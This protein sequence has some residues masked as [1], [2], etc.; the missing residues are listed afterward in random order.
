M[1]I[2]GVSSSNSMSFMQSD[3]FK[4]AQSDFAALSN[5]LS[6][7]DVDAAKTA[8]TAIQNDLGSADQSTTGQQANSSFADLGKALQSG[9]LDSAKEIF[10]KMNGSHHHHHSHGAKPAG[11]SSV[12]DLAPVSTPVQNEDGSY[13]V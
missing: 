3:T 12:M 9:D 2:Y 7:N 6:S 11:D 13:S 5:A 8:Y 10:S 1:S 4:Q